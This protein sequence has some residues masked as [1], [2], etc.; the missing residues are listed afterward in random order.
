V[1][2]AM[3]VLTASYPEWWPIILGGLFI[4]V[5]LALPE[6]IVGLPARLR[7]GLQA[8]RARNA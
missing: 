8:L 5:V 3:S 4:V 7:R 1:N 2:A 6:G